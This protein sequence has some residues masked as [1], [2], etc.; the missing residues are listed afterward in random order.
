MKQLLPILIT[1]ALFLFPTISRAQTYQASDRIPVIDNSQIG[2]QRSPGTNN[3]FNITGGLQRGQNLFHSFTDFSVPKDGSANFINPTGTQ[4]IITRVTG[5]KF[6]D[7]NGLVNT[8]GAN[9]LLINP[10]GVV[11]G[12]NAKLN[13]GKAF[14]TSTASGVDFVDAAGKNYN[15]GVNQSGDALLKIDP[16]VAFNPARLIIGEIGSKGIENYG[17]LETTNQSQYIGLIGGNVSFNGGQIKA[18]GGRVELGGLSAPGAVGLG[19]EGNLLRAQFPTNVTR[20]DVSFTNG[21]RVSVAGAGGGD[22]AITARNLEILG[23]SVIRG[24]IEAGLGTPEAVAGDIKVNATGEIVIAGANSAIANNVRL[25]SKGNGGNI[26][27]D[28]GSLSLQNGVQLQSVTLG[29]GNAGNVIVRTKETVSLTGKADIVSTVEAGGVGKSGTINIQAGSLSLQDGSQL[30]T[31]TRR[32]SA[33]QP[34]GQGDAGNI[35]VKVTGSVDIAGTKDGFLS[36]ISSTVDPGTKGSGGNIT[37]EAGS[38]S[39]RDGAQLR[40][41]T[42]GTGNAGNV[43]VTAKETVSLTGK[44][45]ILSTVEAGGVGKGGSID[46]QA[47]SLSLHDGSQ[48]LSNTRSASATQPAGQGDAGN[49]NV[50]VTGS[51]DIAGTKD[52]FPSAISS[53]V[54]T[55]TKGNGGNIAI[56]AG[57]FS[58]RDGAL[59]QSLTEGT[60]NAGNL[61]VTAKEAVSL[62]GKTGILSTVGTGGVG[63]GGKIDIQAGSLSLQDGAQILTDTS[64]ASDS[65]AAGQGNAGNVNV[66]V[67]GSVDIAGIKDGFKSR[68]SSGV[69][70]GTKG[71]GGNISIDAGSFSLR[72]GALLQSSTLGQGNAGN[73]TID[74]GSFSLERAQLQSSTLAQGNAGNVTLNVKNAVSLSGAA[75]F[76]TVEAGS[77]GKG[78]DININ[79]GSLSLQ[80]G[81]QIVTAARQASATQPAGRGNAGNVNVKVTGAVD[82]AGEKN[83][84]SVSAIVSTV[85]A[86]TV[87]NGGNITIDASSFLLRDGASLEAATVGQGSAGTIK[88]NATDFFTISS[89]NPNL[90]SSV[91]VSSES[92]T[93]IAGDII[94]TSPKITLDGATIEAKSISGN[95]GNINIGG[96]IKDESALSQGDKINLNKLIEADLLVL[97]RGSQISTNA[98][99]TV[100]QGGNGGNININSK[101][102]VAIPKE[103]S[104]ITANA[105]KGRGGNVNIN[106]QGLFGIQFRP[107]LTDNSDITASSTFGQSGSVQISTPGTD[108]GKNKGEL[109]EAPND[110]SKQISQACGASQR[111]NKLYITG[112]GGLPPNANEPLQSEALWED[113]RAVKTQ[114]APTATQPQQFTSPAVG[115][116]FEQNGRVRLIAAQT[117]VESTGTSVACPK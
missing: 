87:G 69:A 86:G 59:L 80:D 64:S 112:R 102:I 10:N 19:I 4:S 52:G 11:F 106:A 3:N 39:L 55:G 22:I 77:V 35:N 16:N 115:W 113:A 13:V 15:F 93:G 72:N 45:A 8:N 18:P 70:T 1:T 83:N 5:D 51:V 6:S 90:S 34:A 111:D 40:S 2:T 58:L 49:I 117:R 37:I 9:F 30:G 104:D 101:L 14:V 67:T 7:I 47:G 92:P 60:G 56:E 26:T 71:N 53:L 85:Q 12:T 95:G 74:T 116:V 63:N 25:N 33:T 73:V 28:A 62:I 21:A 97:R 20:G 24:G 100:Q 42:L 84:G 82:I 108:P 38:F 32:A 81:A 17:T 44:A 65:Q 103:N 109:A 88:V 23:A 75:I 43:T 89:K 91:V 68:I 27:I 94:I 66:K 61:T 48:L 78:G 114:S 41:S 107:S 54:E 46:I 29:T 105:V 50:K 79:A 96:K 99:G 110:A 98:G 76:S 57:S 31:F 36:A